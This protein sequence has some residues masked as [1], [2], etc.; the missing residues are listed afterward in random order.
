[1]K[2]NIIA[3]IHIE[4]AA[5]QTFIRIM[6]NNFVYRH[7]RVAPLRKEHCGVFKWADLT[8]LLKINPFISSLAGHSIVPYSDLQENIPDIRFVTILRDP[9]QRYLSH[10]Q[11]WVQV[12]DKQISFEEFL[13]LEELKDF[14]TKKIAG[15]ANLTA[16]K[17]IIQNKIFL[18]GIVEEFENFLV[19]LKNKMAPEPIDISFKRLNIAKDNTIKNHIHQ[20]LNDYQ[21]RIV[22]NNRLDLELYDFVKNKNFRTVKNLWIDNTAE[23]QNWSLSTAQRVHRDIV[24]KIYRNLYIGPIMN[25]L[26]YKNGLRIGG[27]Y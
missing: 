27:S 17:E 25:V 1:L 26:R 12:L 3:F 5:G 4:K 13:S 22:N 18:T 24:G 20:R 6:E 8:T 2:K 21:E 14:Q 23:C 10:Y 9:I 19:A 15:T 11:Y 16:A 7:C